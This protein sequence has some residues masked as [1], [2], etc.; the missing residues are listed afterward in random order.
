MRPGSFPKESG[1]VISRR[2]ARSDAGITPYFSP[3]LNLVA[4]KTLL[5]LRVCYLLSYFHPV[6]SGA[7]RQALAQ[8]SSPRDAGTPCKW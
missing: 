3:H 8:G 6:E 5:K 7:E 2:L 4:M 1:L